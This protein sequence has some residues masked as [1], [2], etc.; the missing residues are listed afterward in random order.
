MNRRVIGL[1]SLLFLACSIV[2]LVF[3]TAPAGTPSQIGNIEH[4]SAKSLDDQA[5]EL[6]YNSST[7]EQALEDIDDMV[8]GK[9][10]T[11]E[12]ADWLKA[13]VAE[14]KDVASRQQ[15]TDQPETLEDYARYLAG[16]NSQSLNDVKTIQKLCDQY[17]QNPGPNAPI[18]Q[19]TLQ[20]LSQA[21]LKES[22]TILRI[23]TEINL[24]I[25]N[26]TLTN[27][28]GVWL[29]TQVHQLRAP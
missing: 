4:N 21:K 23:D 5:A 1:V 6:A 27:E 14:M 18:T 17:L 20:A 15:T 16:Y 24:L 26:G 13:R 28:Q 22:N 19:S 12:E 3:W 8:Q 25:F 29:R 9:Q 2:L 10:L 7:L 11:A